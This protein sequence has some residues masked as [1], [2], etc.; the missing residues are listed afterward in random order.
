MSN[1]RPEPLDYLKAQMSI[2][3]KIREILAFQALL[4]PQDVTATAT[5]ADL[6]IDSLGI[7]EI[8]FA[9]EEEFGVSV[10]FNANDPKASAFDVSSVGAIIVAVERLIAEQVG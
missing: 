4:E 8:I 6:G 9:I 5:L 1:H 3:D 2:S 10:P 7:V